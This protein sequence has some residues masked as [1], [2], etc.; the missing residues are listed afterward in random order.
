MRRNSDSRWRAACVSRRGSACCMLRFLDRPRGPAIQSAFCATEETLAK[1]R[2]ILGSE[3]RHPPRSRRRVVDARPTLPRNRSVVTRV[4]RSTVTPLGRCRP[5]CAI[6]NRH[7]PRARATSSPRLPI[8]RIGAAAGHIHPWSLK[9]SRRLDRALHRLNILRNG[10][11]R[12]HALSNLLC[13]LLTQCTTPRDLGRHGLESLLFVGRRRVQDDRLHDRRRDID[14]RLRGNDG[15]RDGLRRVARGNNLRFALR[16]RK[17]AP[18]VLDGNCLVGAVVLFRQN[19]ERGVALVQ[20]Y[21]R[22]DLFHRIDYP[23]LHSLA[24]NHV[25]PVFQRRSGRRRSGFRTLRR[26]ERR[27]RRKLRLRNSTGPRREHGGDNRAGQ[28]NAGRH[29]N[30]ADQ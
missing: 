24:R 26:Q 23:I 16:Q 28:Q 20:L 5:T 17:C 18:L 8:R 3:S 25:T 15:R 12:S 29:G 4:A 30:D 14:R 13:R 1:A 9:I 27:F 2:H 11:L 22:S 19:I 6:G 7:A 10:N 21:P